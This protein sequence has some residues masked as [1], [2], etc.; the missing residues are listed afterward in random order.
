MLSPRTV[1]WSNRM[2]ID[3]LPFTRPDSFAS[4]TVPLNADPAGIAV[5]S[6]TTT[7]LATEPLTLSSTLLVFDASVVRIFTLISV[8]AGTVTSRNFG[9]GGGSGA[10]GGAGG[11][12][13]AEVVAGRAS[14]LP[15]DGAGV[16]AGAGCSDCDGGAAALADCGGC[17]A[18][19]AAGRAACGAG[20]TA[21]AG[22]AAGGAAG[23]P[24]P[25]RSRGVECEQAP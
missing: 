9:A 10:G 5:I 3:A 16:A 21:R 2:A 4:M 6:D 24:P 17:S 22:G 19:A 23:R 12:G 14:F 25:P 13:A 1:M 18:G 11:G 7:D 20:C 15:G 8:P